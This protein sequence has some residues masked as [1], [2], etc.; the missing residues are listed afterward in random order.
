MAVSITHRSGAV[1]QG[2][3]ILDQ[4]SGRRCGVQLGRSN[5]AYSCFGE[6]KCR[7][8]PIALWLAR[9]LGVERTDVVDARVWTSARMAHDIWRHDAVPIRNI[10]GSYHS[11]RLADFRRRF[12]IQPLRHSSARM[13]LVCAER[14]AIGRW[15]HEA[16]WVSLYVVHHHR[17]LL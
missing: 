7:G 14:S 15:N 6:Q 9:H 2:S 5:H 10:S 4:A 3:A 12:C 13:G 11:C 1:V 17:H 16:W 8:W